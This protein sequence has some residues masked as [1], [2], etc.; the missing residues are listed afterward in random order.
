[1][2]NCI[3]YFNVTI[4]VVVILNVINIIII[5]KREITLVGLL[6]HKEN[7]KLLYNPYY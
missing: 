7:T 5:L 4:S 2:L 3:D 6:C 1:M